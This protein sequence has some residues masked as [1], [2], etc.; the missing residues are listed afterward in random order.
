MTKFDIDKKGYNTTQV[1]EFI[2]TLTLKY[3]EKLSEQKDR[4][5][6]MRNEIRVL[7]ERVDMYQTK[8]KQISKA[9]VYAVEKAD[10]IESSA[11]KLYE[12]ELKRISILYAKW[13]QLLESIEEHYGS[14]KGVASVDSLIEEFK[15]GLRSICE[16]NNKIANSSVKQD[17]KNNSDNYIKNLLNKMDY[18]INNS[19][20]DT[21]KIRKAKTSNIDNVHTQENIRLQSIGGRLQSLNVK[22]NSTKG[23][24][25]G[26]VDNY[27]SDDVEVELNNFGKN[28]ARNKSNTLAPNDTGFDI[29]DALNPKEDL[30]E[31]MKAFDFFAHKK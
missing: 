31:I 20:A 19:N 23:K 6:S 7:T 25:V 4:V 27:L 11:R 16:Q 10:Q 3:E 13:Q 12:L 22:A 15:E 18:V 28:F 1:D 14:T 29:Q 9:L 8:D 24:S 30:E 2:K 17:I 21:P 26:N 5:F